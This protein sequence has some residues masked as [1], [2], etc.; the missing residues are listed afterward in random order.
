ELMNTNHYL[1]AIDYPY[2]TFSVVGSLKNPKEFTYKTFLY[3]F[4][5]VTILLKINDET[6]K[7][8]ILEHIRDFENAT[9]ACP[10]LEDDQIARINKWIEWVKH[11][12]GYK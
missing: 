8:I 2:I 1:K 11:S 4:Q 5:I 9:N 6:S 7:L 10:V 3:L 12:V